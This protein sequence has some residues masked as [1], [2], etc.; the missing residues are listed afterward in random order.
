MRS[1]PVDVSPPVGTTRGEHERYFGL[2]ECFLDQAHHST[3]IYTPEFDV[4]RSGVIL[5][6]LDGRCRKYLPNASSGGEF[7][8][9]VIAYVHP[10]HLKVPKIASH[11]TVGRCHDPFLLR[12]S[13][14]NS[15]A[16]GGCA[17]CALSISLGLLRLAQAFGGELQATLAVP[18]PEH[19]PRYGCLPSACSTVACECLGL[20]HLY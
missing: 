19:R 2:S 12:R 13:C 14:V 15:W 9:L 18:H 17:A 5:P 4:S 11:H 10:P 1:A 16:L 3:A 7:R 20:A 6:Y 8:W